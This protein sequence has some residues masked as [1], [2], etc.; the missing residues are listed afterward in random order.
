M[1]HG[2]KVRIGLHEARKRLIGLGRILVGSRAADQ[3]HVRIFFRHAGDEGG[4]ALVVV[5]LARIFQNGI[6]TL[7][8]HLL[9]N[10]VGGIGAFAWYCPR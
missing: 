3:L 10:R 1:K 6:F 4:D 8:T 7:A 9:G 2:A 5:V